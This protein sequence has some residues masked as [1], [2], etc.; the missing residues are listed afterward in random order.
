MRQDAIPL[1]EER[2]AH[3]NR[4]EDYNSLHERH[5]IFPAVFEHRNHS[6]IIDLSAGVGVT[7][8]RIQD[9]YVAKQQGADL[10]CNDMCP[11]CLKILAGMGLKTVA[12]DIDDPDQP[13]P[14][15]DAHFDAAVSLATIEHLMATQHFLEEV[16]RIL[17][18]GG[19]FYLSAPNYAGLAY[20]MRLLLTGKTFHDPVGGNEE[21]YEFYGHVRYFTYR[22]LS[23]LAQSFG[24]VHEATCLGLPEG[25]SH[26]LAMRAR[27][28]LK[29]FAFRTLMRI[30][31]TFGSPRWSSE[32]VL[33]LRKP[34]P[35]IPT[36]GGKPRKVIF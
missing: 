28:P 35:G 2:L 26:Y 10:L 1:E 18:P 22:T 25:S 15:E 33:C 16:M 31:Y 23:E 19:A 13:F 20:T 6:T 3:I 27:N 9:Q 4:I 7:V 34:R 24:F 30:L 36:P 5:R 29:A 32:P 8:R 12:F 21:S 17:K 11:K 14:F